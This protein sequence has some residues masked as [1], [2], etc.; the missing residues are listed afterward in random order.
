MLTWE[1]LAPASACLA[2]V[3]GKVGR[4]EVEDLVLLA[5]GQG[6]EIVEDFLGSSD[7]AR[8]A[9]GYWRGSEDLLDRDAEDL[10]HLGQ[11]V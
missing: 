8:P 11:D 9:T 1:A 4:D 6:R 2:H 5:A 3:L 7:R 10:R